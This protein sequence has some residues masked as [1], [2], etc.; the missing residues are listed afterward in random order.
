[1]R[2]GYACLAIGVPETKFHGLRLEKA[3]PDTISECIEHNIQAL[4][5]LI[6]YNIRQGIRLFRISSD[7][8]PFGSGSIQQ[9]PW[10]EIYRFQF[11][12]LGDKIRSSGLRVSMHPGQYTVLNSQDSSI[13]EK[14]REDLLY[15][16]HVLDLMGLDATHKIIVHIGGVYGE[17]DLAISRFITEY[18]RLMPEIR[19][20]LV[21]E[22]DDRSYH[23]RDVL[24]I[25]QEAEIPVVFD[26]LH[27]QVLPPPTD[28]DP[29]QW[30]QECGKTWKA[31]DGTQKIHYSQQDRGKRPGSHS[32]SI[33]SEAFLDLYHQLN[34]QDV[35]LMLE[36]KDKNMSAIKCK[37]LTSSQITVV[38][39]E[40]EWSR[41]KYLVLERSPHLYEAI[42]TLLKDKTINSAT[43]FYRLIE[44]SQS[45]PIDR[46]KAV[47][48]AQHVFG[49]FKTMATQREKNRFNRL[50]DAYITGD[51]NL[52]AIKKHLAK[53]TETYKESYLL[54]SYYF[55][56]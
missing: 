52:E 16:C 51:G 42:R 53:L 25:G 12:A 41:Y 50:M 40:Q 26:L 7:L 33:Q 18:R 28:Q 30:I 20:R 14:A 6:D 15:H 32:V 39:L 11:K 47:N 36:C 24:A 2:I 44:E 23:V 56:F 10:Q 35:D 49:Y 21:I 31:E 37:L 1:M 22:N 29:I 8:I 4:D 54:N 43:T 3:N 27:H 46:G 17:K 5:R 55:N 48:A 45:M 38:D 19:R 9:I 13:V 34:G